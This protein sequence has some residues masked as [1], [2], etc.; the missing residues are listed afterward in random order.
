MGAVGGKTEDTKSIVGPV[1]TSRGTELE[2]LL[3]G[4]LLALTIGREEEG[5][6]EDGEGTDVTGV[7][8]EVGIV[9]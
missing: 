7:T 5:T 4:V 8:Q 9:S 6:W 2:D 3:Q 1:I